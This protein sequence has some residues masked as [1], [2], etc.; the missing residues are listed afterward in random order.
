MREGG[1]GPGPPPPH[2]PPA[3]AA[4]VS[5]PSL[6]PATANMAAAPPPDPRLLLALL[7]LPPLLPLPAP[8]PS[9]C[10]AA[11]PE[12]GRRFAERKR[13]AD[14]ECSMLMC[15]GKA[16]KDFKGPD[17]RFVNFKKGEAVYVY[18]KLIGKSTELWAGSVGSDFGYFPKDL[19][20]VN[21]NYTNEELELP[22]DET[23]FVCFDGGRD[24]FDNY[25]VDELL[26]SSKETI[27]NER[28]TESSDPRTKPAEGTEREEE[29]EKVHT[30]QS[31]DALEADNVEL[32][33]EKDEEALTMTEEL[34]SF[35]IEGTEG[36]R[37]DSSVSSHEENSQ[38]DQTAHEHLQGTLNERLKGLESENTK[39]TSIAQ[40]ETSQLDKESEEVDTYTLLDRELSV[41]L[42]TKFGSTADA[43]VS[44]DEVTRL[45]TSSEDDFNEDLSI[46]A[47]DSEKE[48]DFADPSEEVPLL[49]F[50]AE[51]GSIS[52]GDSDADENN[53]L[54]SK[55]HELD[56]NEGAMELNNQRDDEEER[57]SDALI[58]DAF[59]KSEKSGDSINVDR[60][61]SEQT[62][63]KQ[64]E[65]MLISKRE[66]PAAQLEDLSRE[67]LRH[68][69]IGARDP[70]SEEKAN[71]TEEFE[72]QLMAD[73]MAS[74][75][76]EVQS[77]T[78]PDPHALPSPRDGLKTKSFVESKQDALGLP[79]GDVNKSP[80]SVPLAEIEKDDKKF[81]DDTLEEI[82]ESDLKHKK[83]WEKMKE[84]GRDQYKSSA[85]VPAKPV[86][87]VQNGSQSD[88][89][90]T[91]LLKDKPEHGMPAVEKEILRHEEDSKQRGEADHENRK[92]TSFKEEPEI[93]GGNVKE[94]PAGEGDPSHRGAAE[95]P[96]QWENETEYSEA[97]VKE[98]LSG[99]LG[100]M[101]EFE[102]SIEKS[103]PEEKSRSTTQNTNRANFTQQGTAHTED[104]DSNKNLGTNLAR[105]RNLRP[106]LQPKE[107]DAED[108]A[109]L[110]Q[111][112]EELLEDENAASAKLLHAR[113]ANVQGNTLDVERRNPELKVPNEAFSGTADP[114]YETGEETNSFSEEAEKITNMQDEHETGNKEF[115]VPA[116][117]DAKLDEMEH[118]AED[119][120]ESSEAEDPLAMEEYNFKS[121]DMEDSNDFH[122]R[123][124]HLPEDVSQRDSK[125]M[126]NIEDTGN[127]HQ[128]SA[129]FPSPADISAAT[130]DTV[131]EYSESVKRLTIIRD[132]LDEKRVI[133]LQKYLGLQHVVRIEAM[134]YDMKVEME[135]ARKASNNNE[136]IEK[137]LDQI[138]EFSESNIMDV[139]GKVLD[140]RVAENKEEV[141]KEMDLYD[142]ESALMDDI[143]ELMYS[144]RSKYSSASESV[145]LASFIEQEDDQLNA[146]DTAK[147]AEYDTDA[148]RN[149]D[150]IDESYQKFQQIEDKRPV[151][152]I[153]E[154]EERSVN[155]PPEL[156]EASFSDNREAKEA[157]NSER[158]LPLADTSFGSTDSEESARED[159]AAAPHGDGGGAS[160]A[161]LGGAAAAARRLLLQLVATLP[162]DIRPGPDFHGLPWEPIIITALVGI[163]TLAIIFW[164]TCLSVKSRIYQVTEKQLAEKIKNLLQ[165]KTEIL[166][167]MSE[168]D[169]K[170]KQ[171]K[172]SVKAAQEQ[173]NILSDETAGLKD[174]VKGLE[175][176]NRK[177]DDKIKSLHSMLE[178]ER[179]QNE[180]K[181][182]K[183]SESQKSL[184]KLEEAVSV[185]SAELSEVQI[186]LNEAKL[187]EEKVKSE[188]QH[189]Q[190]EN[191]RLKKSKEQLL[192][193]AE[194]WSERHTEL[195]EQIKLYQKSQKDIEEALAYKENE[196]EVLTNCIMQLKQLD[197][198]P[199]SEAKKDG[200]GHEWSRGD[201][202]AN[203]ELPDN[204]NEKMK[205]QIKQMMDVS[206]VKT[207]LSIVEE[208]RNLLQSKL[209]D[210]VT[211]RHELE[212]QIKKL[213]H[214]SC[215]LQSAKARLENECKTLQQK[216]EILG[217]LYQQ[218]EMALQ[219]K[220]TQEEYERQEK[221]QKLSAADEKAVLAIEEVKVYKQRIQDMEEE[222]QKT[223][224]S[225]KN[226][227]AAHEKKAH[228][229]WLIARSAERAL[230]EEKREA[231]NL[232]QKLIEVNQKIVML[233]RPLI[234]KP[235]PGRPD[236]QVPPRRGPLSRDGSFGPSPVSGGN[237]SPTQMIE[238]PGRPLSAPRRE[239]SRGEFGTVVDGPSVP[240]RPPEIPGRMSV[241][242]LGPAVASL[243]SSGPR[244]SSPST[245]M[246]RAANVSP[247]GPPSFP[248]TPIMTSPVM[249]PPPPPP[250][251]Y[252]PPPA[253]L[254]GHFGP[255]PLPVPLVRGAPLPPPAAR[256]FLPGPPLGMRD[257]PPG[258]L[259]PPPDPRAYGRGHPSFRPLG[260]PG[261][262]DYP[263]G[264]RLPP[265]GSRDYTPSPSRDLPPSG[266]R[267]FPAGPPPPPAGSKDY[268][269]PPAQKP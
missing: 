45:V 103:S 182:K 237:P 242:D 143:Q 251:R 5:A 14:P 177:L 155:V 234:V 179:K 208:D 189:V 133:R 108:E 172:E 131:T 258:P 247:K 75:T 100:K 48:S 25:N 181:Q 166:D 183:I 239:G 101:T 114:T 159:I 254:R 111:M 29:V 210:E 199:A 132:F 252:G 58:K 26:K 85:D 18:Y 198:D 186:A 255:R 128:Q 216:V 62:K 263:Q 96:M 141:V 32:S 231:A 262:R 142:E 243:I 115:D 82:S 151:Q 135:L 203:G 89:G 76:N 139:V 33:T 158:R 178:T 157:Y 168:Y 232:R 91:K 130:N 165:E 78:V 95:Q 152:P 120:E 19:L 65:V 127:D 162:E 94:T 154:E 39:N 169:Q 164:R 68:E 28:E 119:D 260:P 6:P 227:I 265:P 204:E 249:G 188:L 197:I 11:G 52:L 269:Q 222:L 121:S 228:D 63:K 123:K 3:G 215:S 230:A 144:L 217:E 34:D 207:M 253:P 176:A 92:L 240:R 129:H 66:A 77:T 56:E 35:L 71:K 74:H 10:A 90:D 43:V 187:N 219:K 160:G 8:P 87:Q 40:G 38:G 137:A 61:E 70:G 47:H 238:V 109:D 225:Y 93:K 59:T 209:S 235:T 264:P 201:D 1:S 202:L 256:D 53:G 15:R 69:P 50:M 27:A 167:K 194:G 173:K 23:D 55:N 221:E 257:L 193:E 17:C 21:H 233:Q 145:P 161:A 223:E 196:I 60:F 174:T 163:A 246:D 195:S 99:N 184:E 106:E 36:T 73:E 266:P 136:D 64:D 37:V 156:E 192:K 122:Q 118:I 24:D 57:D 175:E 16:M 236:R 180:K 67:L 250:V 46:N 4:D 42:K 171:A 126:Q 244:T 110:K 205:T 105:E 147:E 83:L 140:S 81:E 13:C 190:E 200:E 107:T 138:L 22:T 30:V 12:L 124:D 102:K 112:E 211:A 212:E 88:T 224:R 218:K 2:R 149:P 213:E 150:A 51:E 97:D 104:E 214:D 185:H 241:P 220:L 9:L 259:P 49:S 267:D 7:L 261:P 134:F 79:A 44:D 20:E 248:G 245:P 72:E 153:E 191:A 31:L 229:N 148:V 116:G 84:K 125:E 170:I 268:T 226:Q 41:N 113:V 146:Q 206:R 80:E 98:E 117:E 54:E 86:E